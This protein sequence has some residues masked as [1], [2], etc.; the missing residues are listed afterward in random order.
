VAHVAEWGPDNGFIGDGRLVRF[1]AEYVEAA[2][3]R[4]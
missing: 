2:F 4:P 1:Q 3:R